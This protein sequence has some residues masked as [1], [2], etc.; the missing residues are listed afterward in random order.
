MSKL[1]W[2]GWG[3]ELVSMVFT[4]VPLAA[5]KNWLGI[6]AVFWILIMHTNRSHLL[7]VQIE[8]INSMLGF[9]VS[10]PIAEMPRVM[11]QIAS[12]MT[13]PDLSGVQA[14]SGTGSP[15]RHKRRNKGLLDELTAL[16]DET[17]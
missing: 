6:S 8:K 15:V 5:T 12:R 3:L 10:V 14:D 17:L 11:E 2:L 7:A 16:S 1:M 13:T 9:G 4:L